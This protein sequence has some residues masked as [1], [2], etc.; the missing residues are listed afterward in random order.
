MANLIHT[1]FI[2][3]TAS[4]TS[5]TTVRIIKYGKDAGIMVPFKLKKG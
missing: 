2:I 4:S 3:H 1:L 5:I